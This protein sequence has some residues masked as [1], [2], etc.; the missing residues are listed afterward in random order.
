MR[1][2][3]QNFIHNFNQLEISSPHGGHFECHDSKTHEKTFVVKHI[4]IIL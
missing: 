3:F 4:L 2:F 1:F